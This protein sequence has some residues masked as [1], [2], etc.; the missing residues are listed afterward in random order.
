MDWQLDLLRLVDLD[1]VEVSAA[2]LL[3]TVAFFLGL[4]LEHALD[5]ELF[6]L[7]D[8]AHVQSL[9]VF[10]KVLKAHP[11][12]AIISEHWINLVNQALRPRLVIVT[13]VAAPLERAP[14]VS[15]FQ[16]LNAFCGLHDGDHGVGVAWHETA[17]LGRTASLRPHVF[18]GC[19]RWHKTVLFVEIKNHFEKLAVFDQLGALRILEVKHF[20]GTSSQIHHAFGSV[21]ASER[22]VV[23][24]EFGIGFLEKKN[25]HFVAVSLRK[26]RASVGHAG[27][28]I[29]HRYDLPNTILAELDAVNAVVLVLGRQEKPLDQVGVLSQTCKRRHEPAVA[30]LSLL[31]ITGLDFF[32]KHFGQVSVAIR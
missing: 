6:P 25:P 4:P 15:D 28:I 23:A 5:T 17:F 32:Q 19:R 3:G 2:D 11:E 10:Y 8:L 26:D 20:S 14:W 9:E 13:V 1:L 21:A 16:K 27:E 18:S 29:V 7:A 22:V 30:E 12:S 24:V 31:D